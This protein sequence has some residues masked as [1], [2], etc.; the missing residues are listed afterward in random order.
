MSG[1]AAVG[2]RGLWAGLLVLLASVLVVGVGAMVPAPAGPGAAPAPTTEP[3]ASAV[4][5]CAGPSD[6]VDPQPAAEPEAEPA[7]EQPEPRTE[8][9]T[10]STEAVAMP[11]PALSGATG[12]GEALLRLDQES[13]AVRGETLSVATL[14]STTV[15]AT[16][17]LA[18][19]VAAEV[20]TTARDQRTSGLAGQPCVAPARD[21]WFV[22]GSGQVGR[23]ATL[24]LM[25]PAPS[26]AVVDVTVW[27]EAGEVSGSGTNDL[28]IPA[29][30][31]R[32][33]S[34]DAV[35]AGATS[36]A[37][38]VT[39]SLGRVG[40]AVGLREV[41]GADPI[42]LSW[43]PS[44]RPP[45]RVAYVP[46]VPAAGE[47]TL[48]LLNPG[49]DDAVVAL[50]ALGEQ[51]TFTPLGLDAVDVPAGQVVDVDLSPVEE[52]TFAV[53]VAANVA[54][55]S[56]VLVRQSPG[57]AL[58]DFA[59]AGSAAALDAV[60]A[61]RVTGADERT[62]QIV[63]SAVPEPTRSST[64]DASSP[65]ASTQAVLRLVGLDGSL[66]GAD[67]VTVARGTTVTAAVDLPDGVSDAWVVVVPTEPDL[68]LAARQ[69]TATVLVPDALE[70]DTERDAFWYDL[71]P[72]AALPTTVT[73]PP[74]L[75]DVTAGL[76][77]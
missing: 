61:T 34:L 33:V 76:P 38:R 31:T 63:L 70:P 26:P 43:V 2:R 20:T 21:W 23:R 32:N 13:T 42:G 1:H 17:E 75:P 37:V 50:R 30:G 45:A 71:V 4:L 54:V 56:S 60:A 59:V 10:S 27:T 39:A 47:R 68:V 25:N 51:G 64:P 62:T 36:V 15:T 35:A 40:A 65:S 77:R 69:T 48:R 12:D 14:T 3:L 5:A 7:Q 67:V 52:E 66:L 72:L 53:E 74:V 16:G 44:S 73:V 19:G 55:A 46:G 11:D 8:G 28:G 9:I 22:A 49:G 29:G 6:V 24:V 18:P 57:D 58:P 41:D